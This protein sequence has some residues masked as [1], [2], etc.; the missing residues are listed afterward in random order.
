MYKYQFQPLFTY[1]GH[2][3]S[4]A[5]FVL[6]VVCIWETSKRKIIAWSHYSKRWEG[7]PKKIG[8]REVNNEDRRTIARMSCTYLASLDHCPLFFLLSEYKIY[9]KEK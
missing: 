4:E 2:R 7:A 5:R 8:I 6:K 1:A 3:I 9:K